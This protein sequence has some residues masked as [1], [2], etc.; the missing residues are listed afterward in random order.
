M[1][2][3]TV[4][5]NEVSQPVKVGA[6]SI[7]TITPTSSV[8]VEYNKGTLSDITNGSTPW[9]SWPKGTVTVQTSQITNKQMWV[10]VKPTGGSAVLQTND[11]PATALAANYVRDW[12]GNNMPYVL[13]Q[14]AVPYGIANTGTI[15]T[16]GTVTLGTALNTTY[17]G[18]IWLYFPATAFASGSAGF[19]W[20]VMSSTTAGTVYTSDTSGTP[21]TGS[22]SAYTGSTSQQTAVT[23]T[24]PGGAL[25]TNGALRVYMGA[26]CNNTA[27]AKTISSYFGGSLTSGVSGTTTTI[28]S[29]AGLI[30]NRNSASSQVA[31]SYTSTTNGIFRLFTT[32]DTTSDKNIDLRLQIATATDVCVMENYL[33]EILPS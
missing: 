1:T 10:R 6:G 33:V 7:V 19:Y 5:A 25:G 22:N 16:A 4:K 32:L 13:A 27:G 26:S 18:G 28:F 30:I 31:T 15:A 9:V 17:S 3:I 11:F 23:I 2:T 20:T 24:V 29:N 14:S 12:A 21:V 8:L